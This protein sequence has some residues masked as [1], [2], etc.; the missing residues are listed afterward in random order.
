MTVLLVSP[1]AD[2]RPYYFNVI[3][4]ESSWEAPEELAWQEVEST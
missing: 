2:E 1:S 4:G 3:T